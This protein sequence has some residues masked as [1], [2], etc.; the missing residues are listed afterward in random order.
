LAMDKTKHD[1]NHYVYKQAQK[2]LLIT[3]NDFAVDCFTKQYYEEAITL[4]NKAI[5]N[6]KADKTLYKNRG[7]CFYRT[8]ELHFALSDY[9]QALDIDESDDSVKCKLANVYNDLG[10]MEYNGGNYQQAEE[11]FSVAIS[12]NPSVSSFYASRA[13]SRYMLKNQ[14]DA[15]I[16]VLSALCLD[17][18][19]KEVM[20]LF[21]RIFPGKLVA[22]VLTTQL[23]EAVKMALTAVIADVAGEARDASSPFSSKNV[24]PGIKKASKG[25]DATSDGEVL[26]ICI[27]YEDIKANVIKEKRKVNELVSSVVHSRQNLTYTGPRV[28][29]SQ[30]LAI[31]LPP[32][33]DRLK[34]EDKP[35]RKVKTR[36][37]ET[38]N[39]KNNDKCQNPKP[40]TFLKA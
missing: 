32:W 14:E 9:L 37:K 23:G 25:Q 16:D 22:E 19:N 36:S 11:F 33:V 13:R 24:L 26:R 39:T 8:K 38:N 20:S 15:K 40:I 27:R 7:D 30:L 17:S 31:E 18:N 34:E 21:A 2:Q 12:Y 35:S 28:Q 10:I 5:K 29:E 4:L 3:Y 6:E 1:Q